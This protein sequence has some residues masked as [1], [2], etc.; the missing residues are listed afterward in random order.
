ME[1]CYILDDDLNHNQFVIYGY[2]NMEVSKMN[3]S[4]NVTNG[5]VYR[6]NNMAAPGNTAQ[7]GFMP[8]P[9]NAQMGYWGM[10]AKE[11]PELTK[12]RAKIGSKL[13]KLT[14]AYALF[15][16]FCLYNNPS[17]V[18]M[19]LFAIGTLV[20]ICYMLNFYGYK[21]KKSSYFYGIIII[22]LSISNM[23]TGNSFFIFF[24]CIGILLLTFVFLLHNV[25]DDSKW[26]L[27]KTTLAILESSFGSLGC[28]DDYIKDKR[29]MKEH[30]QT[31]NAQGPSSRNGILGSVILGLVIAVPLVT[32][33]LALLVNADVVF[34]TL[35]TDYLSIK[36]DGVTIFGVIMTFIISYFASFCIMRFFAKKKIKEEVVS[37]NNFEPVVAITVL[38]II[39]V[40]YMAFSLIQIIFL[41][42]GG[43]ALPDGYTYA[44]YAREGFFQLL[45]V[46][47][48]N[49]IIVIF[50]KDYYREHMMLKLL[51]TLISLCTYI[52]IASSGLRMLMYIDSYNLSFDRI[53]V[54]WTLAVLSF[55]LVGIIVSI[56][57][58][59]FPLFRYGVI[60]VSIFYMALSFSHTD[61]IIARYNLT[62]LADS[63]DTDKELVDY[64]YLVNNMSTDAAPAMSELCPK[65]FREE[66][67][68]K[69]KRNYNDLSLRHFNVSRYTARMLAEK[70]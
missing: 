21:I 9:G 58:S 12:E 23:L 49:V 30:S 70:K 39:G 17:G 28:L 14:F 60:I 34:K 59:G 20:Y 47:I 35:I 63:T 1:I 62:A 64:F 7:Q 5:S 44:E 53:L 13:F 8:G 11:T 26:N 52:M 37:H 45:T 41:F 15:F 43:M 18:T 68:E 10:V 24:N 2:P 4:N 27:P 3:E 40:I 46:C 65:K 6:P 22:G 66:Y 16:T 51:M 31:T 38:S 29:A 50:V 61:N 67:F 36:V 48:I 54:L 55:L 69:N 42:W 19:P 57:K 32:I 56:Y 33:I 25:Y